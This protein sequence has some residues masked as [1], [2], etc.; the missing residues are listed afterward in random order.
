VGRRVKSE[1]A[2]PN[3]AEDAIEHE[4]MV[5]NVQ[6]EATGEVLDH[7]H[8][9]GLTVLL[10]TRREQHP[11]FE[12]IAVAV[13]QRGYTRPELWTTAVA[14]NA[15]PR[16]VAVSVIARILNDNLAG[17]VREILVSSKGTLSTRFKCCNLLDAIYW[18]MADAV[19]RQRIR[20]CAHCQRFFI[21]T[22]DYRM[23]YCPPPMGVE[24]QV[25][26]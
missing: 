3:F 23:K 16:Q 12:W 2:W 10:L 9:A 25:H 18:Q 15:P 14:A 21:A 7:R 8:R 11:E 4:R 17:V 1:P 20:L 22:A 19:A 6:L 5:V 24:G 13:P 26:A